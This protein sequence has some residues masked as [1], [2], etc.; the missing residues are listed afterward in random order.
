MLLDS[1]SREEFKFI[2]HVAVKKFLQVAFR[3]LK[4]TKYKIFP[5]K[6]VECVAPLCVL[7]LKVRSVCHKCTCAASQ[8]PNAAHCIYPPPPIQCSRRAQRS[9]YYSL[10]RGCSL[11][12]K[13]RSR[14][15]RPFASHL[16]FFLYQTSPILKFTNLLLQCITV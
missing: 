10:L 2:L 11:S 7:L 4:W 16:S 15:K 6:C 5:I 12:I 13:T 1:I 9:C 14:Y 8:P 3:Q